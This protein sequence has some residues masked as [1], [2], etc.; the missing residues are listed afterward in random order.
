MHELSKEKEMLLDSYII[1]VWQTM[2]TFCETQYSVVSLSNASVPD[3]FDVLVKFTNSITFVQI[4]SA[5][6]MKGFVD[7]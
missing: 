3:T 1:L 4:N 2:N 5:S 6:D 7:L